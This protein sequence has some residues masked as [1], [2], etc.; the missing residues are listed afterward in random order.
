MT[1]WTLK[2]A[3]LKANLH[4]TESWVQLHNS[5]L[6]IDTRVPCQQ[7]RHS[8]TRKSTSSESE[9][10][11]GW[12]HC[13]HSL[14]TLKECYL[15]NC[16][17]LET[18]SEF[19]PLNAA[20]AR[21]ACFER[22]DRWFNVANRVNSRISFTLNGGSCANSGSEEKGCALAQILKGQALGS[23][24]LHVLVSSAVEFQGL[25]LSILVAWS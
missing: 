22:L 5:C 15:V 8:L 2:C 19:P 24:S 13:T 11:R 14:K 25:C 9:C 17:M 12:K 6:N 20:L 10:L 1:T 3:H 23:A 7:E 21:N 18:S 4:T 16:H